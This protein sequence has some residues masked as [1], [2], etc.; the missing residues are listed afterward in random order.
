M[1]NINILPKWARE[2]LIKLQKGQMKLN[3]IYS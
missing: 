1:K 2:E 3:G